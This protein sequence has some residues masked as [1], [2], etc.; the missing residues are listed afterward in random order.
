MT[1]RTWNITLAL[2]AALLLSLQT[3]LSAQLVRED[4]PELRQMDI[5]EHLGDTIPLNLA[6][7]NDAGE[8]VK[9]EDYFHQGKPVI[10][11]LAYYNCPML[12]TV[13]LNG[14][15]DAVRAQ[16]LNLE[17]D[18]MI[19]TVSIN[20]NETAELAEGKRSRY[21]QALGEKGQ[22]SGWRFF[23]GDS[24]QSRALAEAI[25]FKYY[26]DEE[27]KEYAHPAGAFVLTE[28]G[29][30]SRYLYGLEFKSRDLKLALIEAADGKIGS[31][32]DR[33]ILYCY[34]YDPHA[35]GYVVLAGNIMKLGGLVTLIILT[36]F[37]SILWARERRL[38]TVR[39]AA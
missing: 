27:T 32:L 26:Y 10:V 33:L 3:Q 19:L 6:F 7:T 17:E 35:K 28:A 12:C 29:V 4:V 2:G 8:A 1:A 5:V 39:A 13:V 23:V 20:P 18:F 37:L 36:A 25:G 21:M 15:S 9:L 11:T 34:H 30:I 38:R 14:L 31:T 16:E 24:T 22:N